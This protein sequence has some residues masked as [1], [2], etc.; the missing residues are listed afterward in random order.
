MSGNEFVGEN[1][2]GKYLSV[3]YLLYTGSFVC[4]SK[5]DKIQSRTTPAN[6]YSMFFKTIL[7]M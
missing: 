5:A 4:L 3:I 1:P 6:Y 7:K 2:L